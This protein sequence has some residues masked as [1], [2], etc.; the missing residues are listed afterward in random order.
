MRAAE[1]AGNTSGLMGDIVTKVKAGE[2]LVEATN[3]AFKQVGTSSEK[4]VVLMGEIAAASQEQYQGIE[5]VNRAVVEMNGATQ[6]NAASAEE[7]AAA[8]ATFKT[9]HQGFNDSP[10]RKRPRRGGATPVALPAPTLSAH[11]L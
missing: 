7:L 8:V 5:Q 6:Q 4:V 11:A 10:G 1:A 2:R 3:S 9:S